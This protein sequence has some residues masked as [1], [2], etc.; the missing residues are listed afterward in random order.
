VVWHNPVSFFGQSGRLQVDGL[1]Q[2]SGS[3]LGSGSFAGNSILR[4]QR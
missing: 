4:G 2:G 3:D 1:D